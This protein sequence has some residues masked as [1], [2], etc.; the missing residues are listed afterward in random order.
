MRAKTQ[1]SCVLTV[2]SQKDGVYH[3]N[4]RS[5]ALI[6]HKAWRPYLKRSV[7]R[8]GPR[9]EGAGWRTKLD[10]IP[11]YG[12]WRGAE[13]CQ[14]HTCPEVN[15]P[16]SPP[17]FPPPHFHPLWRLHLDGRVYANRLTGKGRKKWPFSWL[18]MVASIPVVAVLKTNWIL[19][20]PKLGSAR[21]TGCYLW[22][23]YSR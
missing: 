5:N 10:I 16:W 9:R 3:W 1:P 13:S 19:Q 20:N 11:S 21:R 6:K 12:R 15:C 22:E 2:V 17:G 4:G 7:G 18:L 14:P 23:I 8:G